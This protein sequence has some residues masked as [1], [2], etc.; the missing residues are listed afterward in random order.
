MLPQQPLLDAP[1]S[2]VHFH[3]DILDL[4]EQCLVYTLLH[5]QLHVASYVASLPLSWA[6]LLRIKSRNS[7]RG[8]L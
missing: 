4:S 5:A 8:S 2:N 6:G 3:P 7:T 1:M